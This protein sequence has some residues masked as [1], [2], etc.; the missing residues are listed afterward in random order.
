MNLAFP[1][2]KLSSLNSEFWKKKK[3][4]IRRLKGNAIICTSS[5]I[6]ICLFVCFPAHSPTTPISLLELVL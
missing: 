4:G 2:M 1:T 6:L 5:L 3:K